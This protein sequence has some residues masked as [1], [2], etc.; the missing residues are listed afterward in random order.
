MNKKNTIDEKLEKQ[1]SKYLKQHP[2]Y[3]LRHPGVLAKLEIRHDSGAAVSLI[4]HKV[5]ILQQ[6]SS[7]DQ[8][9]VRRQRSNAA[10]RGD[11]EQQ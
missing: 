6:Q 4:E 1:I 5:K 11:A 8:L 7:A 9:Y 3:L 10:Q 2:D